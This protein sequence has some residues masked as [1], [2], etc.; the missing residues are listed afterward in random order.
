[1]FLR[2]PRLMAKVDGGSSKF[3][4]TVRHSFNEVKSSPAHRFIG[5]DEIPGVVF[6]K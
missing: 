4:I 5:L 6:H 3:I 2:C 1:M